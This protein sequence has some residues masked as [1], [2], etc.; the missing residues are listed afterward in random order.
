MATS[1][2]P[3]VDRIMRSLHLY[4]GLF[5]SPWM[6]VYATSAFCL[7]HDA[8]VRECLHVVSPSWE[9]LREVPFVSADT[10]PDDTRDQ[11]RAS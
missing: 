7:N 10:L 4:T 9:L 8:W 1:V 2:W 3:R 5:L 6:L 11:A